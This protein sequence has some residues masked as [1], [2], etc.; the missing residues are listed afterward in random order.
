MSTHLVRF[1]PKQTTLQR[2]AVLE[3]ME[4]IDCLLGTEDR[5]NKMK[6]SNET[7]RSMDEVVFQIQ[8]HR[9]CAEWCEGGL[10]VSC[11]H[12]RPASAAIR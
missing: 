5:L 4:Q 9:V 2:N 1:V 10:Q 6:I 12:V 7:H 8:C 11:L 3:T